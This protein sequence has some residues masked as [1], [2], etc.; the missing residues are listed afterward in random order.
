MNYILLIINKKNKR[1]LSE[2]LSK[3][4]MR[5][6]IFNCHLLSFRKENFDSKTLKAWKQQGGIYT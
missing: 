2:T 5:G 6:L 4:S 3:L 1:F